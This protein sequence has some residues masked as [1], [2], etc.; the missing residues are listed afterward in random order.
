MTVKLHWFLLTYGDSRSIVGGGY[1][2]PTGT[3]GGDRDAS[4]GHLSATFARRRTS[5]HWCT[6][7]GRAVV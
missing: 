7:P 6:H 3:A 4:I 5:V 1:G 2:V